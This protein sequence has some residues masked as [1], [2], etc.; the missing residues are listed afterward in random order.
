M[1]PLAVNLNRN[2]SKHDTVIKFFKQISTRI[3][4]IFQP[5]EVEVDFLTDGKTISYTYT[6]LHHKHT[7]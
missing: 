5:E 4:G 1:K 3:S 7:S 2:S 6:L